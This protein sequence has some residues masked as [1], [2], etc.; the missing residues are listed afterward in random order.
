M[1]ALTLA[2]AV[3][4]ISGCTVLNPANW[5]AYHIDV[6]QGNLVTTSDVAKL[7]TG[8]TRSQVKFLL[9]SPLLTDNFHPNRW[10]YKFQLTRN[11]VLVQDK[12]LTLTFEGDKLKSIEG[13]AMEPEV[14][15]PAALNTPLPAPAAK[16]VSK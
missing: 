2:A 1:R 9:G 14:P 15:A 8:M 4:A 12:L 6:Q 13:N 11:N 16:G 10:D 5:H 3:L 7:K